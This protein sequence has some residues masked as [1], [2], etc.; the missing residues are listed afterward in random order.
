LGTIFI[1]FALFSGTC[2]SSSELERERGVEGRSVSKKN[3]NGIKKERVED[4]KRE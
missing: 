3:T 1:L 4:R 2:L